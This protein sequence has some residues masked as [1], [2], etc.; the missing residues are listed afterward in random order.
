MEGGENATFL[1]VP[2]N[3]ERVFL[4]CN[5]SRSNSNG[6]GEVR[7]RFRKLEILIALEGLQKSKGGINL[8][9]NGSPVKGTATG[10]PFQGMA[11][12]YRR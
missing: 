8:N 7:N 5:E 4:L 3:L 11:W 10:V 12:P 1:V 2:A 9:R 6:I